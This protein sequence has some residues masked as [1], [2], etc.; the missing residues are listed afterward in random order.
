MPRLR[1][2]IDGTDEVSEEML[3][4]GA[5][6]RDASPVMREIQKLMLESSLATFASHGGRIDHSWKP[7]TQHTIERKQREGYDSELEMRTGELRE[8]LTVPEG[9]EFAGEI[10]RVGKTYSIFGTTV[11][12]AKWQ[13]H[14]RQLL[15]VTLEDANVWGSMMID[16]ILSGE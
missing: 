4:I 3:A 7:D 5:R 15:G 16:W 12:H 11:S 6:A 1:L 10:R 9:G 13:G 2:E 8:S 14:L